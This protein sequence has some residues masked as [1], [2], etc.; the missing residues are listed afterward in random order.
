MFL[1]ITITLGINKNIVDE[2]YDEYVQILHKHLILQ[3]HEVVG[4]LVSPND[5]TMNSYKPYQVKKS[6]LGISN[7]LIFI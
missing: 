7:G 3:T 1:M 4:A 2:Y 6:V 5:I